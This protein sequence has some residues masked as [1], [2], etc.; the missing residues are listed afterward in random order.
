[1]EFVDRKKEIE[2]LRSIREKFI[3]EGRYSRIGGWWDRKGENEID[4]VCENE[5]S[6]VLDF[7]EVKRDARRIDLAALARKSDAFFKKNP[8]LRTRTISCRGIS[9]ADM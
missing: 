1:M 4:L 9:L 6:N 5:F 7:F 2:K 3:S 8:N